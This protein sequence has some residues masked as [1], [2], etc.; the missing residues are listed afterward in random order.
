MRMSVS[1]KYCL[2][3]FSTCVCPLVLQHV[4]KYG[5]AFLNSDGGVL[6]AGVLDNGK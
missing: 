6:M 2:I 3:I 5:S 4:R 1:C